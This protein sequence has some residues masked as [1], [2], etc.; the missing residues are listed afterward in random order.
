METNRSLAGLS[1]LL[2]EDD[3]EVRSTLKSL[4]TRWGVE[5]HDAPDGEAGFRL[6]EAVRPHAVV[7]DIQ[8]PRMDGFA[9]IRAIRVL[10]PRIPVTVITAHSDHAYLVKAIELGLD[11]LLFK[12]VSAPQ[13][14]AVLEKVHDR[15]RLES[16]INKERQYYKA[17]MAATIVSKTDP[18]GV[19]TDVN[20]NFCQIS[21]FTREEL[22]GK[23]HNIVRHPDMPAEGFRAMWET[24]G[25]GQIW[26]GQVKNRKKGGGYYIVS[27]TIVPLLDDR[28]RIAEYISIRQ[29]VTD[30]ERLREEVQRQQEAQRKQQ[31]AQA[32]SHARESLL[33]VFT[34]ELK[35]PLNAIINFSEYVRK[36]IAKSTLENRDKLT[37]LLDAVRA[38]AYYMLEN[39]T[40]T[41]DIAKL[42]SG[43]LV[44]HKSSF[45]AYDLI[46]QM[47]ARHAS[48]LEEQGATAAFEGDRACYL[49]SD[50]LRVRQILSN[51]YSNAIKYGNGKILVTLSCENE[52]VTVTVEDDGAGIA[53]KPELFELFEQGDAE[54]MKRAS[55]GTGIG[56]HFVKL[57]CDGLGIQTRVE[58]SDRLGGT[59]FALV[60][61]G[62]KGR[63]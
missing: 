41:L 43:K 20:D 24:I 22:I 48:L 38:N 15:I 23:P 56:L 32:V 14:R 13:L 3:E 47:M 60:F 27:T 46:E 2:V 39:I 1:V 36:S 25:S 57:L 8:M 37:Q 33:L 17:L 53:G 6:Y 4:L 7:T 45:N 19:I 50:E 55:K 5:V 51:L 35:T 26:H 11:H 16:E 10:S 52:G 61:P 31:T 29:D 28:G 63:A 9:M 30:L 34:H 18:K 44:F 54:E 12:P 49:A 62:R 21:G 58:T 40:N 59:R 42:K